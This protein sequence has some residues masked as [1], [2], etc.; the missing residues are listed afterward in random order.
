MTNKL[1]FIREREELRYTMKM[2]YDRKLTNSA[3]GNAAVLVDENLMLMT[4]SMMAEHKYCD[5]KIEDLLLVDF[6]LNILEGEGEISREAMMHVHLLRE[7]DYIKATV[8]AHPQ[9]AMVYAAQSKPIATMTDFTV[10]KG[11]CGVVEYAKA[12][13]PELAKNVWDYFETKRELAEKMPLAAVLPR[14]GVICT[15][16][17]LTAAYCMLERLETDALCGL[18][19]DVI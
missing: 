4:P 1:S 11:D 14:H 16:N 12:H 10:K 8:H 19:R 7:F 18:F 6:D 9:F 15:G 5:L 2:M 3:G 13:T 17:S